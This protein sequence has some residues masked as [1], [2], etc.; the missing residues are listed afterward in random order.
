MTPTF[1]FESRSWETGNAVIGIDEVGRGCLAGPVFVSAV[2][3]PQSLSEQEK[4]DIASLGIHDSKK[5]TRRKR[6]QIATALKQGL[7]LYSVKAGPVSLINKRGIVYATHEAMYYAIHEL[8]QQIQPR[9]S[10]LID[11]FTL[12]EKRSG[13]CSQQGIIG[14]D[15][16]CLSIAA[17]SILAKVARDSYMQNLAEEFPAYGWEQN[18]GYGTKQHRDAIR[19]HGASKHHRDLFIRKTIQ[20]G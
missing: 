3:F 7:C 2:S 4:K 13:A 19:T 20:S 1:Q 12:D 18:K 10:L 5:L 9:Y 14:G 6:E 17:A 8:R 11:G 15:G 16:R